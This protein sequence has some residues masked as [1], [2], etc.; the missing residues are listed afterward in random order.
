MHD[1]RT[2]SD[3]D[4]D[5]AACARAWQVLRMAHEQVARRLTAELG[6]LCNLSISE[7]DVLLCMRLRMEP[8]TRMQDLLDAV[9]LSQPALSRLVARL[10]ERGLVERT[11]AEDD[12]RAVLVRLTR[13]G[14]ETAGHAM[15]VHAQAVRDTLT[16]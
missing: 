5:P 13:T 9:V 8:E 7:F 15:Q 6:R 4:H 14:M 1:E 3:Q 16:R 12:G 2:H 11:P 10:A